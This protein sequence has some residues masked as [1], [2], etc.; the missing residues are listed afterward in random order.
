M[1]EI[2]TLTTQNWTLYTVGYVKGPRFIEVDSFHTEQEAQQLIER[3][4]QQK[5]MN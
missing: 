4:N 2:H 1:Y 5:V 3:L